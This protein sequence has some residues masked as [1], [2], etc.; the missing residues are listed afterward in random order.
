MAEGKLVRNVDTG[1]GWY[2]PLDIVG[3]NSFV[4]PVNILNKQRFALSAEILTEQA[5]LLL[6]S[7][8]LFMKIVRENPEVAVSLINH[9]LEQM[10]KYQILWLQA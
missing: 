9:V 10:E 7:R 4:N 2:N 5:E 1:D 8:D 3:K 6:I